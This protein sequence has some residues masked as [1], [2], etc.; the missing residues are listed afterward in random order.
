MDD[1]GGYRTRSLNKARTGGEPA[2]QIAAREL[3]VER[4][5]NALRRAEELNDDVAT[6][7]ESVS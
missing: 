1:L 7:L 2:G 3:E 4:L 6:F 5:R